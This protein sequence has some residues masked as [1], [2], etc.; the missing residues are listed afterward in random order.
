MSYRYIPSTGITDADALRSWIEDNLNR[1]S[2][3]FEQQSFLILP[4]LNKAPAKP[5]DGL[6]VRA[7][8]INWNPGAGQGVYCF[9]N[10]TWNHMG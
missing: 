8:G 4:E 5:R 2:L 6:V 3:A 1:I 10:S 7:D 9:Y